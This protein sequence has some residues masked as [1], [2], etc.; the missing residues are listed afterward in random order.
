M[1]RAHVC[2][3]FPARGIQLVRVERPAL[4]PAA[5]R[6]VQRLCELREH[7]RLSGLVGVQFEAERLE[8]DFRKTVVNHVEGGLLLGDE[9]H[10]PSVREVVRDEV[11]DRLA[12]ARA[13]R[14]MQHERLAQLGVKHRRE[15]R[16]V[17]AERTEQLRRLDVL[18][19]LL[20]REHLHA[21]VEHAAAAHEVV[22]E[23]VLAQRVEA[24]REVLPHHELAERELSERK[25]ARH[26]PAR[27]VLHG[28]AE[29][30][31]H[32][33]HV[34]A[35]RV[36][37]RRI[38]VRHRHAVLAAQELEERRV[39]YRLLVKLREAEVRDALPHELHG[40]Q[41]KR[42]T[43]GLLVLGR[44][45]PAQKADCEEER[46]HAAFLEVGLRHAEQ[47][48]EP[49]FSFVGRAARDEEVLGGVAEG[50]GYDLVGRKL[51]LEARDVAAGEGYHLLH[52]ADVQ[53][54]VTQ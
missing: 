21:V 32:L 37:R 19:D 48:L 23:R 15:L 38:D 45:L 13:G 8:A 51:V 25:V 20:R 7:L 6:H 9:E 3:Q 43:V 44:H 34:H 33:R 17:C 52:V 22:H 40:H 53:H 5:V 54:A 24:A 12:L 29:R 1:Q 41:E 26:L 36:L 16:G 30:L 42:R 31:N 27:L 39:D 10:P 18:R 50:D 46:V 4:R 35:M 11:R 49:A 14:T 47:H 2:I 28:R